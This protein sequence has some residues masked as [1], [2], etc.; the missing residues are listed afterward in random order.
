MAQTT[1]EL[2][3]VVKKRGPDALVAQLR[4]AFGLPAALASGHSIG[5]LTATGREADE[6]VRHLEAVVYAP[7]RLVRDK[8]VRDTEAALPMSCSMASS[9]RSAD[10]AGAGRRGK[11]V[12]GRAGRG[13][14]GVPLAPHS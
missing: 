3:D 9:T 1:T 8:L 10:M 4:G 14:A 6:V 5:I 11:R 13:A 7:V 12:P 2:C